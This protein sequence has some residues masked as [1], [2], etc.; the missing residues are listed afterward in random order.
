MHAMEGQF[1]CICTLN[2]ASQSTSHASTNVLRLSPLALK[3]K[4]AQIIQPNA[5]DIPNV[6]IPFLPMTQEVVL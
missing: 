1:R 5:L 4:K 2:R 6:P 3:Q